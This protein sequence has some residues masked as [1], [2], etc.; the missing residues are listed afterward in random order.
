MEYTLIA[1]A[2]IAGFIT[3][4]FQPA[5]SS[6]LATR[7]ASKK[8]TAAQKLIADAEA[9]AK[10]LADAKAVVAAAVPAMPTP[11]PNPKA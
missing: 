10:A 6:F 9:A 8:V 1:G 5:I 11:P 4:T 2:Y 7:A 3:A